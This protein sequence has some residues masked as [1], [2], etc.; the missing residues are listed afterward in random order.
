MKERKFKQSYVLLAVS[1]VLIMATLLLWYRNRLEVFGGG[2]VGG[3]GVTTVGSNYS[4]SS[5]Q[6][7]LEDGK[8]IFFTLANEAEGGFYMD[9]TQLGQ[10]TAFEDYYSAMTGTTNASTLGVMDTNLSRKQSKILTPRYFTVGE[11]GS[12]NYTM[13]PGDSNRIVSSSGNNPAYANG[14]FYNGLKQ[15]VDTEG[16]LEAILTKDG[17]GVP[18]WKSKVLVPMGD[19]KELSRQTIGYLVGNGVGM[20]DRFNIFVA[21]NLKD[22]LN[23]L[24]SLTPEEQSELTLRYIDLLMCLYGISEGTSAEGEWSAAIENYV[25]G[26]GNGTVQQFSDNK[27]NILMTP[28]VAYN[29]ASGPQRGGHFINGYDA[30]AVN[31]GITVNNDLSKH[32]TAESI[33]NVVGRD[34]YAEIERAL[35]ASQDEN[36]DL[37]RTWYLGNSNGYFTS[38]LTNKLLSK[39]PTKSPTEGNGWKENG[40]GPFYMNEMWLTYSLDGTQHFGMNVIAPNPTKGGVTVKSNLVANSYWEDD[41]GNVDAGKKKTSFIFGNMW[42]ESDKN[43]MYNESTASEKASL[44]NYVGSV[45]NAKSAGSLLETIKSNAHISLSATTQSKN[46][47]AQIFNNN[48]RYQVSFQFS[49]VNSAYDVS[50]ENEAMKGGYKFENPDFYLSGKKYTSGDK[51]DISEI[52]W[53]ENDLQ[54]FI[55]G[56]KPFDLTLDKSTFNQ[57]VENNTRVELKYHITLTIYYG[58]SLDKMSVGSILKG[59]TNVLD[60]TRIDYPMNSTGKFKYV[61]FHSDPLGYSELKE[62]TVQMNGNGSNESFDAMAGVPSTETLY[63]ASGGSEF[64]TEVHMQYIPKERAKRTYKSM[65]NGVACEFKDGDQAKEYTVPSPGNTLL[66]SSDLKLN[67]HGGD[68]TVSVVYSGTIHNDASPVTVTGMGSAT[69]NCPAKPNPTDVANRNKAFQEMTA[70]YNAVNSFS[71]SHTAASDKINRTVQIGSV[72]TGKIDSMPTNVPSDTSAYD[73]FNSHTEGEG[74][75]A[76]EVLDPA[77]ATANPGPAVNW[78]M[79][80]SWTIPQ[81][82]ICGPCC[83]HDLPPVEDNWEQDLTYSYMR[84]NSVKSWKIDRSYVEGM[85]DITFSETDDV[86]NDIVQGDPNIFYNIADLNSDYY[87]QSKAQLDY[88][89]ENGELP[90]N[91]FVTVGSKAGR[92]RY[93]LQAQQD[94]NVVWAE[95]HGGTRTNKCDGGSSCGTVCPQNPNPVAYNQGHQNTWSTGILYN[96]PSP[97]D[98]QVKDEKWWG[99]QYVGAKKPNGVQTQTWDDIDKNT[100]EWKKFQERRTTPNTVAVLSDMLV[101]QTSSGDQSVM[102]YSRVQTRNSDK[103]FDYNADDYNKASYNVGGVSYNDKTFSK[104]EQLYTTFDE[105]YTDNDMSASGWD[106]TNE[107]NVGGYN[108]NFKTPKSKFSGTNKTKVKTLFDMDG[109]GDGTFSDSLGNTM[110]RVTSDNFANVPGVGSFDTPGNNVA[111]HNDILNNNSYLAAPVKGEYRQ[112]RV[113]RL[114]LVTDRDHP[115][116]YGDHAIRQN[117]INSNKEYVTGEAHVFYK[118]ILDYKRPTTEENRIYLYNFSNDMNNVLKDNGVTIEAPYSDRHDKINNIVVHDPVSVDRAMLISLPSD[119]DQRVDGSGASSAESTLNKLDAAQVCPGTPGLCEFRQLDCKYFDDVVVGNFDFNDGTITNKV[120]NITYKAP[121][122]FSV[123][124]GVLDAHGTRLSIPISEL[125]IGF[126]KSL[127]LKA[128]ADVTLDAGATNQMIFSFNQYDLYA[129]GDGVCFNT[130]NSFEYGNSINLADGNKHHIE[131]TFDFGIVEGTMEK[132]G[133]ELKID[134]KSIPLTKVND[135]RKLDGGMIGTYF[136]IG[137]WNLDDSYGAKLQMDNLKITK[138]GG[139]HGHTDSC[140]ETVEVHTKTKEYTDD[141]SKVFE[142]QPNVQKYIAPESGYYRLEA[143]GAQGGDG[144]GSDSANIPSRGGLGGYSTGNVYL[145]KGQVLNIYTGGRGGYSSENGVGGQASK[146]YDF[147]YTGGMQEWTCPESGYYSL[148]AWGAQ[149]GNAPGSIDS[150]GGLGG[151]TYGKKYFNA[152]DK[153]YVYVGGAG[154]SSGA[155]GTGGG[156]NGGGQGGPGG[157]GGGGMSHISTVA[158]DNLITGVKDNSYMENDPYGGTLIKSDDDSG[159]NLNSYMTAHLT[160]GTKYTF[161]TSRYS[162]SQSGTTNWSISG[163]GLNLSGTD[164]IDEGAWSNKTYDKDCLHVFTAP[165]TG[166]YTFR[167]NKGTLHDPTIFLY[168]YAE[169]LVESY[170]PTTGGSFN[171]SGV[172]IAAGGG[173]GGD[174]SGFSATVVGGQDDGAGGAGGGASGGNPKIDGRVQSGLEGTQTSGFTQGY[175]QSAYV[176]ADTG[177]AGGGWYGGKVTNHYNGGAG[178]GSGHIGNGVTNGTTSAGQRAG[179]GLVRI[180]KEYTSAGFNGGG[181]AGN[182]GYGGGGGTDV[183]TTRQ[184]TLDDL[185]HEN[186]KVTYGPYIDLDAGTYNV[187]VYGNGFNK[188]TVYPEVYT[189]GGDRFTCNNIVKTNSKITYTVN[190]PNDIK[191]G[192]NGAGLEFVLHH[193]DNSD[194]AFERVEIS[195]TDGDNSL[196]SRVIVAGGGGGSD[197]V[198]GILGGADDGTGGAGGGLIAGG[199]YIDGKIVDRTGAAGSGATQTSGYRKFQGQDG[200][201]SDTGGGGGGYYGATS[202][203]HYNGGGGGGSGFTSGLHN[204]LTISGVQHGNGKVKVT[205]LDPKYGPDSPYIMSDFNKHVHNASCIERTNDILIGAFLMEYNG[206]KAPL[207]TLIGKPAYDA[208]NN[209]KSDVAQLYDFTATSSAQF[210]SSNCELQNNTDGL[211]LKNI[212]ADSFIYN[213]NIN[214]PASAVNY[215]DVRVRIVGNST[216]YVQAYWKTDNS[217]YSETTS[218]SA[219]V[220]NDGT[221]QTVRINVKDN[222]NWKGTIKGLRFDLAGNNASGGDIYV[223]KI[224][225]RGNGI[226]KATTQET[227]L[228]FTYSGFR[229]DLSNNQSGNGLISYGITDMDSPATTV[230]SGGNIINSGNLT[231]QEFMIPVSINDSAALQVIEVSLQNNTPA[232]SIG[233]AIYN[234]AGGLIGQAYAYM[235][236]YSTQTVYINTANIGAG[237]IDRIGFDT[238]AGT[239]SG[240]TSVSSIKLYGYGTVSGGQQ[241]GGRY[242]YSV[243]TSGSKD[244]GYTGGIQTFIAPET[245]PYTLEVWG[246]SGGGWGN[247]GPT[248]G[249]Y[250]SGMVNLNAGET[251]Y[252]CNGGRGADTTQASGNGYNGGASYGRYGGSGGATHIAKA[253]GTLSSLSGNRGSVLIVAGGGGSNGWWGS[254]GTGGGL[255]GGNSGN[256][257]PGHERNYN[258]AGTQTRS[259]LQGNQGGFGYGGVGYNAGGSGGGGWYGGSGAGRY[260]TDKYAGGGGGSGYI[261][262][263][264]NGH[265]VNGAWNGNGQSKVSWNT[266]HNE[267]GN[268]HSYTR[269]SVG[270]NQP[271]IGS[272]VFKS[273]MS[274]GD[275]TDI[276]NKIDILRN[277]YLKLIPE[278]VNGMP[279]PVFTCGSKFNVFDCSIPGACKTEKILTCSEPHHMNPPMHYPGNNPICWKACGHDEWHKQN[280]REEDIDG[281]LTRL[282]TFVNTDYGFEIYFP[283]IG[284]FA[285]KTDLW[286]IPSPTDIRGMGYVDKMDVTK[287]TREKRV[288]FDFDTLFYNPSTEVWEQYL[289]GTWISLPVL[290]PGFSYDEFTSPQEFANNAYTHYKFYCTLN[291]Q[292]MASAKIQYESEAINAADSP[293]GKDRPYLRSINNRVEKRNIDNTTYTTNRL[294]STTFKSKHSSTKT[295]Y[296]DVVGRIGNLFVTDTDDMRFCNFF[297]MPTNDGWVI[298]GVLHTVNQAIQNNFLSWHNA[299]GSAGKDIRGIKVK[300]ETGMYN[301]WF[302]QGWNE[303]KGYNQSN[304]KLNGSTSVDLPLTSQKN[305]VSQLLNDPLKPGYNIL[306][307]ISTLGMYSKKMQVI[308]HFYAL[309]LCANEKGDYELTPVDVYMTVDNKYVPINFYDAFKDGKVKPEL[310]SKLFEHV[311]NL[312]WNDESVRRNYTSI[313]K[314]MT[315]ELSKTFTESVPNTEA[316][317]QLPSPDTMVG[318]KYA[319]GTLQLMNAE[320]Y[321]RTFI[322][323][324]YTNNEEFNKNSKDTLDV[325]DLNLGGGKNYTNVDELL[326]PYQYWYRGQRWHL[327][328]G[329]P[330]SAVFVKYNGNDVRN[331]PTDLLK[332]K[333]GQV[334][335][336]SNGVPKMNYQEIQDGKYVIL[337]TAEITSYGERWTL[338]YNQ[339]GYN[340]KAELPTYKVGLNGNPVSAGNKVFEFGDNFNGQPI[341]GTL[342]A[343][344]DASENSTVDIDI[345]GSH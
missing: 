60:A 143:W 83:Q 322:G 160:G 135:S 284:D 271:G 43:K 45:A 291:N 14:L 250:S 25:N 154:T 180:K 229:D 302:S 274:T 6:A 289:A 217:G 279:N 222:L 237:N 225:L 57:L 201:G 122:G 58:N 177:G 227:S 254:T 115:W 323:S 87:G 298:E 310:K 286:G 343:V 173:G 79:S 187:A 277:N 233:V 113:D 264:Y 258:T 40:K 194:Y 133:C 332:D 150:L 88:F 124:N 268:N 186:G 340:G 228:L 92:L 137:S 156:Y 305:N 106:E 308:P 224:E 64:I 218:Q 41:A 329:L 192:I 206:D 304:G 17:S 159:G 213:D 35:R 19:Y 94:D 11:A 86:K 263:V 196:Q 175:G 335:Y 141:Q 185:M 219:P 38:A 29:I 339:E 54:S 63:F 108:G 226:S 259:G 184:Y 198:G 294:R 331:L 107:I 309:N 163:P 292:E 114:R 138:L 208:L 93:S 191:A 145:E 236:P 199:A 120:S 210:K 112:N 212:G 77:S 318:F 297:K 246:A 290:K 241:S 315:N 257:Q 314:Y 62:G 345:T 307:E 164:Y 320:G 172:L 95:N 238:A 152:G 242:Q 216:N 252:I 39:R 99:N 162:T 22:K 61:E 82:V 52:N 243:G 15:L 220:N 261:G 42:E 131:A 84:I 283:N 327:K 72:G 197:N 287:W 16:G 306:F 65:F 215:I 296:A 266:Y 334:V 142:F 132:S 68:L 126:S 207:Q 49:R 78:T 136:N 111:K 183:R 282:G 70:W 76:H 12:T 110:K 47:W 230:F 341:K 338:A 130:G 18:A 182:D 146:A 251:L 36:K 10:R 121:T 200:S 295:S 34:F 324:P 337:M 214:I 328:V 97:N 96:N 333:S 231:G 117:P 7:V 179:N 330:S 281:V 55:Y 193:T 50:T 344:Y 161:F 157:Y 203:L 240:T 190:I 319:L 134:G 153:V 267:Q 4:G 33:A 81:H 239:V 209:T 3:S 118:Q 103:H 116:E 101:L 119:R 202:T 151:Y 265:T 1:A 299:D 181:L 125:G 139:S 75:N 253:N 321:A 23:D 188:S 165:Q 67:V 285:Q 59:T 288:K 189:T 276:Q 325:G 234:T 260:G 171:P 66:T 8:V 104:S 98:D 204:S 300:K 73:G 249:G 270:Y 303:D 168:T 9:S 105:L 167:A 48:S 5:N 128:E 326:Q 27:V 255:E 147:N 140:Y 317:R 336:D 30:L 149:G 51:I 301:T 90:E 223:D 44:Q 127:R 91:K 123:Q 244:F 176:K 100:A 28:G 211:R 174:N 221:W 31:M 313:E 129:T 232:N 148:E 13:S 109:K 158:T 71:I 278:K 144:T 248:P 32:D 166:T 235:T 178:G 205:P 56:T 20:T 2:A 155:L 74:E 273:G 24:P 46:D 342:M 80:A 316:S 53:S 69:A 37:T 293:G 269:V 312:E 169:K 272:C 247:H 195:S 85:Q 89:A 256:T 275:V 245:G 262:G 21:G 102:Y 170:L 311:L 280:K 26:G